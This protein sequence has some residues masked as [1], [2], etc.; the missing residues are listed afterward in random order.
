MFLVETEHVIVM[1]HLVVPQS[2]TFKLTS[3]YIWG[4]L[5]PKVYTVV[6]QTALFFNGKVCSVWLC[7]TTGTSEAG[8]KSINRLIFQ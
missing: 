5:L 1:S 3:A 7:L 8:V 4:Q 2:V 6:S